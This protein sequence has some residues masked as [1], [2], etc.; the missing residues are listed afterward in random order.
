MQSRLLNF[1]FGSLLGL[2]IGMCFVVM[3]S[4][5]AIAHAQ[6]AI[7]D[8]A[9]TIDQQKKQIEYL[10]LRL[11]ADD[12]LIIAQ[13]GKIDA[14][15]ANPAAQALAQTGHV[16]TEAQCRAWMGVFPA[17]SPARENVATVLYESG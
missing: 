14:A 2:A 1:V 15:L 3:V 12:K 13:K 10:Q 17:V 9:Q 4:K 5:P 8:Q 16:M 11:D 7:R 6:D